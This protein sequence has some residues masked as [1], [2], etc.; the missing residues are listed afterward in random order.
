V[1]TSDSSELIHYRFTDAV[2]ELEGHNGLRVH[3]SL[4]VNKAAIESMVRPR[5]SFDIVLTGDKRIPVGQTY[6]QSAA[7]ELKDHLVE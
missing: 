6:K 2:D 1:H 7:T 3:R 4:W 5:R